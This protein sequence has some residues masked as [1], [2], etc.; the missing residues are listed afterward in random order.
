MTCAR[1]AEGQRRALRPAGQCP[2]HVPADDIVRQDPLAGRDRGVW[3]PAP[4]KAQ[5][6][7]RGV[8]V[9]G[10]QL[11]QRLRRHPAGLRLRRRPDAP[12][13]RKGLRADPC[14]HDLLPLAARGFRRG[15]RSC[16]SACMARWNSCRAS[17]PGMGAA[18]L[19]RP[20]DR[21]NCR[22]SI[23]MPRTTRPRRSLAKRRSNA[24]TITHLTP[25]LAQ[26]GLYKG[27]AGPEG[28]PD[29][30]ARDGAGR[31]R[32][33]PNLKLLIARTGGGSGPG[34]GDA[35]RCG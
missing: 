24:I 32:P 8:F 16:T 7:G 28:Q 35:D 4:G 25:P 20:A 15:C 12:S 33:R 11:R 9:L 27:L 3:G 26:A 21:R 29:A 18:L 30:L 6:D 23:F 13:V 14:L 10:R 2:A 17:R 34:R 1:R 19:A 22:T 5:S 31:T